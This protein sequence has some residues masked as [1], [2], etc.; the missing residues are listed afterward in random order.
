MARVIFFLVGL[1]PLGFG[2]WYGI[3]GIRDVLEASASANWPHVQGH[4]TASSV[5]VTDSSSRKSSSQSYEPKITY[6]YNVGSHDYTGSAISP[7]R[8]W[9]STNAY[10]AVKRFAA[11][12]TADISYAPDKPARSLLEP[13]FHLVNCG[14]MLMGVCAT[15]FGLLF[16]LFAANAQPAGAR[17]YNLGPGAK[18]PI[19]I[20]FL[21][22]FACFGALMWL[23]SS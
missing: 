20:V 19:I 8:A 11:G 13:G 3:N 1:V 2:A 12:S 4:I 17:N 5:K 7:G 22:T 10:A 6:T 23:G 14:K 18:A 16:I 21:L 15:C 9:G